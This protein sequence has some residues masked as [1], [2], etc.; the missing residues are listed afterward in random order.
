MVEMELP[1]PGP[2]RRPPLAVWLHPDL[3]ERITKMKHNFSLIRPAY[4]PCV[5]PPK[6]WTSWNEGGWHTRALRR[7]LPYPDKASG[8]ARELLKDHDM[9]IVFN[10]LNTL[11]AVEWQVNEEVFRVVDAV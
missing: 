1:K 6:P 7:L 5:E 2:G 9:P 11:Q 8:V 4:G 10:C 3:E